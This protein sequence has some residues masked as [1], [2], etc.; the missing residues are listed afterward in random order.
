MLAVSVSPASVTATSRLRPSST[1]AKW[2]S[3]AGKAPTT[4]QLALAAVPA[5]RRTGACSCGGSGRAAG[6]RWHR[7]GTSGLCTR[8]ARGPPLLLDPPHSEGWVVE[9]GVESLAWTHAW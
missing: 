2:A 8:R 1:R 9:V 5:S 7:E 3:S 6:M 4:R